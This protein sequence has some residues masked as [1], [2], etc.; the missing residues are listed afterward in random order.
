[1][2]TPRPRKGPSPTHR[3]TSAK[4]RLARAQASFSLLGAST[5]LLRVVD[6]VLRERP[7]GPLLDDA[8]R[9]RGLIL[10]GLDRH[11]EATAAFKR[12]LG[13]RPHDTDLIQRLGVSLTEEGKMR[14]AVR[15]LEPLVSGSLRRRNPDE[16]ELELLVEFCADAL[17][18]VRRGDD[19]V[20]LIDR[21]LS[22]LRNKDLRSHLVQKRL[23]LVA[24]LALDENSHRGRMQPKAR[25]TIARRSPTRR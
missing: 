14:G 22:K 24:A 17:A 16:L 9:L 19:A 25:N 12:A 18:G 1:M 8:L 13:R 6:D 15:L 4:Q 10:S 21:A 3:A 11:Q 5:Q 20:S 2:R 7:R 23:E